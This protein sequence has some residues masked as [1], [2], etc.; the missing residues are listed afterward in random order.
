M[1]F[2]GIKATTA[3]QD[4]LIRELET[5]ASIKAI[6][7]T[8][9]EVKAIPP[10][11]QDALMTRG[12]IGLFYNENGIDCSSCWNAVNQIRGIMGLSALQINEYTKNLYQLLKFQSQVGSS[13]VHN[14]VVASLYLQRFRKLKKKLP[15]NILEI[16][17]GRDPLGQILCCSGHGVQYSGLSPESGPI[18]DQKAL[19]HTLFAL[20]LHDIADLQKSTGNI[21]YEMNIEDDHQLPPHPAVF[22]HVVLEHVE[23]P[24]EFVERL[25]HLVRPGG[26]FI[27][28]I[29]MTGH[30]YGKTPYDFMKLNDE[31]FNQ[32]ATTA[33]TSAVKNRLKCDDWK[34]LFE[35]VGFK[36]SYTVKSRMDVP[37]EIQDMYPGKDITPKMAAFSCQRI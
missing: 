37:Q 2:I 8:I 24:S 12:V 10:I 30:S 29:D 3:Q 23:R 6:P 36:V 11:V 21:C 7:L 34:A 19:V 13:L 31:E 28:D 16:G 4:D 9:D 25:S 20:G 26:Y 32:I 1:L 14:F 18:F 35:T 15:E 27:T 22:S 33:K 17:F 5:I